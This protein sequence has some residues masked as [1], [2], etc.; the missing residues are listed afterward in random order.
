MNHDRFVY[1]TYIRATAEAVWTALT[2]PDFTRR[3]WFGSWQDCAWTAGSSWKLILPDGRVA[4]A[5]EVL[6]VDPPRRLVLKWRHEYK[7]EL[8]A[9]GF[10]RA[11]FEIEPADGV[12]KLT[13]LHEI[14]VPDSKLIVAVSNGW[15]VV[16]SG[17]KTL[18]ETGEALQRPATS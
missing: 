16:L 15:P 12:V 8:H 3:Y 17:L 9:E 7:P 14:D 11:T 6:E 2:D 10:S 1:V 13:V 4:D 5:G 18:L